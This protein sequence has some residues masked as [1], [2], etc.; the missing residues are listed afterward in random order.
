MKHIAAGSFKG[1]GP[2][3]LTSPTASPGRLTGVA[4]KLHMRSGRK[5]T[6]G[7]ARGAAVR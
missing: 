3:R 7:R 5:I 2:H 1:I 4:N 6:D